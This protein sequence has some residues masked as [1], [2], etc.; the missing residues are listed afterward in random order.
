MNDRTGGA[1]RELI[2]DIARLGT[3]LWP[4]DSCPTK[5]CLQAIEL[6][7]PAVVI[8]LTIGRMAEPQTLDRF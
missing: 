1:G 4:G 6:C 3:N 8:R 2:F 7:L 5:T